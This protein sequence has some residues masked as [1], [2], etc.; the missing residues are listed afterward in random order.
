MS[1]LCTQHILGQHAKDE[2][3]SLLLVSSYSATLQL[4]ASRMNAKPNAGSLCK[5]RHIKLPNRTPG[6]HTTRADL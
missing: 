1:A 3:I 2:S 6:H 4:A 5:R